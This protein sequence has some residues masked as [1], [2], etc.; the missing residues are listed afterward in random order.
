[1][2]ERKTMSSS[3]N[4]TPLLS[5]LPIAEHTLAESLG[6]ETRLEPGANLDGRSNVMRCSVTTNREGAPSSVIV[7]C[8]QRAQGPLY[9][10]DDVSAESPALPFFRDWLGVQFLHRVSGEPFVGPRFY[11]GDRA[12]GVFVMEDLGDGGSLANLLLGSDPERATEGLLALASTLGRMHAD[13]IG[14]EAVFQELCSALGLTPEQVAVQNRRESTAA[15]QKL[16]D[17]CGLIGVQPASGLEADM[18][19]ISACLQS[20]DPFRAYTH[21][22]PCPDNNRLTPDGLRLFDF[23]HGG[24][25]HALIDGMYGRLPFP[26]CWCANR[27]PVFLPSQ[28]EAAYRAELATA[29]PEANEDAVFYR[30]AT[31]ICAHWLLTTL[32]WHFE[33]TLKED[34]KWGV[35][36]LRQRFVLRLQN[37]ADTSEEWGHLRAFGHTAREMAVRL[38]ALWGESVEPMPLYPAFRQE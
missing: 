32:D 37:F 28:M 16:Q 24:F 26:T 29:C 12:H 5:L 8:A 3:E 21:G 20:P 11:G 13:S 7:K 15:V 6:G 19:A 35:S 14:R 34:E 22:D 30:E 27:L 2:P 10:P 36:S 1:M 23:E 18:E 4:A 17:W 31:A 25:R 33:N 9:N 38:E